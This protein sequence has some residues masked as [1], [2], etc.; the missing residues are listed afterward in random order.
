M[1]RIRR[2]SLVLAAL[3]IAASPVLHA[4]DSA[5]RPLAIADYQ[6]WRTIADAE[7]SNDGLWAAWTYTKVRG[8]DTL[9]VRSLDSDLRFAVPQAEGGVFSSDGEWIAFSVAPTFLEVEKLE[10]DGDPVPIQA[11]L[12]E[13]ATGEIR[14]W[15][16][17]ESFGFSESSSHFFVKKRQTDEEAEHEGTDLI[18][19][20]L[21][22]A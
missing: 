16:D 20:N 6:L 3:L 13:L 22:E 2:T 19:R 8:D 11:G 17:A 21:G 15:D 1:I 7:I 18:L 4:Q 12:L 5:K 14:M 9:A 10:R